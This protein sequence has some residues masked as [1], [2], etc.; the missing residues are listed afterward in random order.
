MSETVIFF[1]RRRRHSRGTPGEIEH[2]AACGEELRRQV[3]AHLVRG[4]EEN[5]IHSGAKLA[6]I[7]HRLQRQIDNAF[8]LRMQIETNF[9]ASLLCAETVNA[10]MVI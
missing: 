7:G 10:V 2:D 8:Q 6:D 5:H 4:G 3:M 9:P 1:H